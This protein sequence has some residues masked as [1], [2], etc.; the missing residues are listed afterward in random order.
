M[1]KLLA[2]L[3]LLLVASLAYSVGGSLYMR[4][5]SDGTVT[6]T[7]WG[8]LDDLRVG[9]RGTGFDLNFD[10]FTLSYKLRGPASLV[11]SWDPAGMFKSVADTYGPLLE[12]EADPTAPWNGKAVEKRELSSPGYLQFSGLKLG[13]VDLAIGATWWVLD[14]SAKSFV[15]NALG[16]TNADY[17]KS[18]AINLVG[19]DLALNIPIGDTMR[20]HVDP[21]DKIDIYFGLGGAVNN[22]ETSGTTNTLNA[23]Y[24]KIILPLHFDI[25]IEQFSLEIFPKVQFENKGETGESK[26]AG[27]TSTIKSDSSSFDL[28]LMV[29]A[30]FLINEIL[31]LYAHLGIVSYS[32]KSFATVEVGGVTTTNADTENKRIELP[33]YGGLSVKPA[34]PIVLN[35]GIG[36]LLP[37]SRYDRSGASTNDLTPG[38]GFDGE[39]N[40]FDEHAYKNPFLRFAGSAKFASD[41]EIG[42]STIVTLWSPGIQTAGY[43]GPGYYTSTVDKFGKTESSQFFHFDYF[44]DWDGGGNGFGA[45]YLQFS[46]DNVTIRGHITGGTGLWGLFGFA[47][48]SFAF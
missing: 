12:K 27:V 44:N 24:F 47:D 40:F 21:W 43:N 28:G 39:Y 48:V 35:L 4:Y 20:I 36:Y 7:E 46:K 8:L 26:V 3:L 2:V 19:I 41:W 33:L 17:N 6:A 15:T 34:G 22:N 18:V 38:G 11:N 45:N 42:M 30:G 37:V 31:S 32:S 13:P 29:R 5:N 10:S 23:T 9:R 25:N 14:E 1:K 16:A